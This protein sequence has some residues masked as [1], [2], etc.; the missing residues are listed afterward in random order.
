MFSSQAGDQES[1]NSLLMGRLPPEASNESLLGII[2][3][4][5]NFASYGQLLAISKA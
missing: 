4:E 1:S 5:Q 2:V 3:L